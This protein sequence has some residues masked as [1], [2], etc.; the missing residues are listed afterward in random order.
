PHRRAEAPLE[1]DRLGFG[2]RVVGVPVPEPVALDAD[3]RWFGAPALVMSRLPGQAD[4]SP[5][6]LAGWLRQLAP[7]LAAIHTTETA[8]AAGPLLGEPPLGHWGIGDWER[9]RI[10][11]SPLVDCCIA[12]IRG[13][14]LSPDS[15][16][17][18][19]HGDFHPGN[20]L[21]NQGTLSG[22]VDWSA[23]RL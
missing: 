21:W 8:G 23:A 6:D 2:Q 20:I 10:K 3:G 22:V 18:L 4:V 9:L 15:A 16:P 13:H 1:W 5:A 14:R 12:A 19:V 17:V 7:V 11:P